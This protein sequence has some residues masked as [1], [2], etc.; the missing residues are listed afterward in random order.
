MPPL[1]HKMA[2]SNEQILR[3]ITRGTVGRLIIIELE[4]D[5][6]VLSIVYKFYKVPIEIAQVQETG[7]H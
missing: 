6:L 2:Y 4:Q 7:H 1:S 3:T 5:I